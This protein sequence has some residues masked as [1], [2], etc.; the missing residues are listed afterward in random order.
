MIP[1]IPFT[2]LFSTPHIDV[3]FSALAVEEALLDDA[4][5]WDSSSCLLL[6]L[7]SVILEKSPGQPHATYL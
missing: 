7:P 4:L 1:S 3:I 6:W 5:V 2:S